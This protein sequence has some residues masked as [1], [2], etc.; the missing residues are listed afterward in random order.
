[1]SL[2]RRVDFGLLSA[3]IRPDQVAGFR[4]WRGF[5][6]AVLRCRSRNGRGSAIDDSISPTLS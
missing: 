6:S 3:E 5:L 2:L 4:A 1:M